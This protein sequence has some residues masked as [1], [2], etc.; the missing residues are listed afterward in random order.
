MLKK[1]IRNILNYSKN[2]WKN[3]E[4]H[5]YKIN[6]DIVIDDF[7]K[8][9]TLHFKEKHAKSEEKAILPYIPITPNSKVLDLGCGDGRWGQI[10]AGSCKKYVGVDVSQ[11]MLENAKKIVT[12]KNTTFICQPSQEYISDEKFDFILMI[13]LLTY[14]NDED[15]EKLSINCRKMLAKNGR[16]IVRNV[17]LKDPNVS[18]KFFDCQ[19]SRLMRFLGIPGYQIIRRNRD[20]ELSFFKNF[21][22]IHEQDI[23]NTGYRFY[24]LE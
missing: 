10:L 11:K 14:L 21:E 9:Q 24:V 2:H 15:I 1:H 5:K 3:D 8:I 4:D 19:P 7:D 16:L 6:P 23:Q 17:T 13:G 12:N 18:R 20:E 22:L